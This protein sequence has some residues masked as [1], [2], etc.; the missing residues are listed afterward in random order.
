MHGNVE[1][2]KF[3]AEKLIVLDPKDSGTYMLLVSLC[4]NKRKWGDVRMARSMMRDN[5]VKKTPGSSSIELEGVFHDFLVADELHP[6]SEAIYRVLGR[7]CCYHSWM[8]IQHILAR[9]IHFCET[10]L[11]L[12]DQTRHLRRETVSIRSNIQKRVFLISSILRGQIQ[13][14]PKG[15]RNERGLNKDL[16]T[17]VHFTQT[18]TRKQ[19]L[20]MRKNW[21]CLRFCGRKRC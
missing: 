20:Q 12:E 5:G 11:E 18:S 8:I 21:M 3:A 13:D 19:N 10:C 2:G 9:L 1:L 6:E 17:V 14:L 15:A 4:A 7:F 16:L